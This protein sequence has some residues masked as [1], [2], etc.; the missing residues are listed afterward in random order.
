MQRWNKTFVT[1]FVAIMFLVIWSDI[2]K[3]EDEEFTPSTSQIVDLVYHTLSEQGIRISK[4]SLVSIGMRDINVEKPVKQN[5]I[6][7][8]MSNAKPYSARAGGTPKFVTVR[9]SAVLGKRI[10]VLAEGD[11]PSDAMKSASDAMKEVITGLT[12]EATFRGLFHT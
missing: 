8:M 5:V 1:I 4:G 7:Q 9:G 10:Y 12:K 6:A 2:G 11:T 3:P